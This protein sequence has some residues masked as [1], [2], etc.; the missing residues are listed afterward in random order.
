[1]STIPADGTAAAETILQ[2]IDR[3][4]AEEGSLMNK[5]GQVNEGSVVWVWTK[6]QEAAAGG[7]SPEAKFRIGKMLVELRM[8]KNEVQNESAP[9]EAGPGGGNL[10]APFSAHSFACS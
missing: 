1:M 5:D 8:K 3:H 7:A 2:G 4:L 10:F 9:A 6:L